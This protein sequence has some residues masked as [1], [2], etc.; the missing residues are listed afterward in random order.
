M[1]EGLGTNSIHVIVAWSNFTFHMYNI[2]NPDAISIFKVE[3]T[4][5]CIHIR[6]K[7]INENKIVNNTF[8]YINA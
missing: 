1:I 7:Y 4:D 6:K 8:N 3:T 2:K 5:V